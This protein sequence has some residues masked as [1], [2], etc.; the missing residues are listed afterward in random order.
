MSNIYRELG[1]DLDE[2]QKNPK[3]L[4]LARKIKEEAIIIN[5][6]GE[7]E[8]DNIVACLLISIR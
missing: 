6:L 3:A 5:E 7:N 2:I 1:I 8:I 4:Q